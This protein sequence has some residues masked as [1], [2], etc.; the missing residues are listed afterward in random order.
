MSKIKS[1]LICGL[2]VMLS[3]VYAGQAM[4]GTPTG[5]LVCAGAG[6]DC[7][8]GG[9]GVGGVGDTVNNL[10]GN[11][12]NVIF[13]VV[14]VLAVLMMVLGGFQMM[15]STGDP[16]KIKKGKDT[17]IWGIIGLCVTL[18]S[19]V[20]VNFVLTAIINAQQ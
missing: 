3:F 19:Y 8:Q 11:V 13:A 20:I 7:G 12:V 15:T 14:G 4:A 10:V 9:G 1:L 16:G 2:A 18:F 17:I 5:D 6:V